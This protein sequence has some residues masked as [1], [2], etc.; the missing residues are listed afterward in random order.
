MDMTHTEKTTRTGQ[1]KRQTARLRTD[2]RQ[3]RSQHTKKFQ[4]ST[5]SS[6]ICPC[7]SLLTQ[8]APASDG[9]F[10]AASAGGNRSPVRDPRQYELVSTISRS[11]EMP[12]VE[13]YW[14]G[15]VRRL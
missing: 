6:P 13:D 7:S 3:T 11:C 12:V 1:G 10:A 2:R 4:H 5:R 15:V 8:A 14:D 9:G